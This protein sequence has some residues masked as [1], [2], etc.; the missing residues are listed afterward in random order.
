MF[1]AKTVSSNVESKKKAL[2]T[3]AFGHTD[4]ALTP[5]D[6]ENIIR[7]SSEVKTLQPL[8]D[9]MTMATVKKTH[10]KTD[11]TPDNSAVTSKPTSDPIQNFEDD[12]RDPYW[13]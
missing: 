5:D 12:F 13:N 2:Q 9:H 6:F 7:S 3:V 8:E 10:N 1:I 11:T 4:D